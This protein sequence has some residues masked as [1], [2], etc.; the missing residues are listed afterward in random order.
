MVAHD[1]LERPGLHVRILSSTGDT[2]TVQVVDGVAPLDSEAV[3]GPFEIGRRETWSAKPT[4]SCA[5]CGRPSRF[6]TAAGS[7][8]MP[9][10]CGDRS[11]AALASP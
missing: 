8:L 9:A 1:E 6:E 2:I 7:L 11:P 5:P 3:L 10:T 4:F